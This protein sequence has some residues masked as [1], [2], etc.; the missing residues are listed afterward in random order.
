MVS[1]AD[2]RPRREGGIEVKVKG[3]FKPTMGQAFKILMCAI[4]RVTM[5]LELE[6]DDVRIT[7]PARPKTRGGR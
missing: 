4:F 6:A 7:P 1:Q 5:D 3:P 2:Y